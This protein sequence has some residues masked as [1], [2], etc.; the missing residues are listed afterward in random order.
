MLFFYHLIYYSSQGVKHRKGESGENYEGLF[1]HPQALYNPEY[2]KLNSDIIR[3]AEP[4][5][6]TVVGIRKD[7]TNTGKAMLTKIHE[8]THKTHSGTYRDVDKILVD[9]GYAELVNKKKVAKQVLHY[10]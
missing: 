6:N 10:V 3:Q 2:R 1:I 8:G 9:S 7:L 4:Y 5:N